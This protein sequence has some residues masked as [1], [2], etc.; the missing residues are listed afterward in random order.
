MA[1]AIA[2]LGEMGSLLTDATGQQPLGLQ[3]IG[4]FAI[5]A[6]GRPVRPSLS[7]GRLIL[8]YLALC[9]RKTESRAKLAAILWED[10]E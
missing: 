6:D 7:S 8:A 5:A 9:P 10:S 1:G 4:D 2:G 3:L